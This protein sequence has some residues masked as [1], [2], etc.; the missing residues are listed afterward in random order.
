MF[1]QKS[2][3]LAASSFIILSDAHYQGMELFKIDNSKYYDSN[4][5]IG[6]E[7]FSIN[8]N[9][10]IVSYLRFSRSISKGVRYYHITLDS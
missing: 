7:I 2:T 6:D 10:S 5:S 1:K 8:S 4:M 9:L 3:K